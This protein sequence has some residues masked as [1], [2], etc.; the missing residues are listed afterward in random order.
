MEIYR[1]LDL[2]LQRFFKF[3]ETVRSSREAQAARAPRDGRTGERLAGH[4]FEMLE[5]AARAGFVADDWDGTANVL[6]RIQQRPAESA[7]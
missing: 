5:R 4:S 7:D 6:A 1:K 3:R 2:T